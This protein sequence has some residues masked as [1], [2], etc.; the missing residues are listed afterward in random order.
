MLHNLHLAFIHP[1][2]LK[3]RRKKQITIR[4][5]EGSISYFK[6]VAAEVDVPYQILINMY[7]RDCALKRRL[8]NL[9]WE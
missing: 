3:A 2:A 1:P 7:L 6:S 5:D 9:A 4:L 8:P